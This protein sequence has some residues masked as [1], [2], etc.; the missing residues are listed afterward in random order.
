MTLELSTSIGNYS[1]TSESNV[2]WLYSPNLCFLWYPYIFFN[3]CISVA[4]DLE[5]LR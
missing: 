4:I 2:I 5:S 1:G 3:T